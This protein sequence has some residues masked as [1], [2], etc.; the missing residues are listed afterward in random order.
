MQI[1]S[2]VPGP[3]EEEEEKGPGFSCLHICL[4]NRHGIP[5][6]LLT[7]DILSYTCDAKIDTMRYAVCRFTSSIRHVK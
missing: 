1:A 6:Q 3:E 5:R 4:Y 2:L 7:T